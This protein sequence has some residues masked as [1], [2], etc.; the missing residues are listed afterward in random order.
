MRAGETMAGETMATGGLVCTVG[1]TAT[2]SLGT[3]YGFLA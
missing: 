1:E 2:A 3:W